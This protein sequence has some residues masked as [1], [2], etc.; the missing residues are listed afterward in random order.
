M[1]AS[2]AQNYDNQEHACVQAVLQQE[3]WSG[4]L[5]RGLLCTM[6]RE[7]PAY[8]L[9]FSV[10]GSL[11]Q[12]DWLASA[13][14]QQLAPGLYGAVAGCAC[15]LPIYPID[16]IKTAVQNTEGGSD[17]SAERSPWQVATEI[18]ATA[19]PAAFWD[20]IAPRL[21]RQAV[22]HAVTFSVYESILQGQ[23]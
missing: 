17:G 11:M 16:V 8:A 12:T 7:I 6:L 14:V 18:Y 10:Y 19:G 15:W 21:L 23:S 4:L 9:Y 13:S 3:G 22:N 5:G 1:Q 20:G 2:G